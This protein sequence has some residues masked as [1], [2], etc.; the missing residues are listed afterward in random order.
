[1]SQVMSRKLLKGEAVLSELAAA[2]SEEFQI[3]IGEAQKK[4][5]EKLRNEVKVTTVASD[6][7]EYILTNNPGTDIAIYAQHPFYTLN[8]YRVDS[9]KTLQRCLTALSI[10]FSAPQEDL[11]VSSRVATQLKRVEL[12]EAIEGEGAAPGAEEGLADEAFLPGLPSASAEPANQ[13]QQEEQGQGQGQIPSEKDVMNVGDADVLPDYLDSFMMDY[14]ED[15]QEQTLEEQHNAE[16]IKQIVSAK[17]EEKVKSQT[18]PREELQDIPNLPSAQLQVQAEE[19]DEPAEPLTIANFFI[20]KLKEADRRL[21]DYTKNHPSLKKY[22]SQCQVTHMRQPA[23][24]TEAKYNEMLNE[25]ADDDVVFILYPLEKGEASIPPAGTE[26]YTV[27]RY[28]SSLQN[29]NYYLCSKYFCVRDEILIREKDLRGTRL[30]RPVRRNDG[31]V[32]RET[33]APMTCPFC[34]GTIITNRDTPGSNQTVL[35][36]TIK[37]TTK[38]GRHLYI[39]FLKK[40]QHPDGFPLPCCFMDEH[41]IRY[42]DPLY[43]KYRESLKESSGAPEKGSV[44]VATDAGKAVLEE[45]DD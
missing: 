34:E 13:E 18:L 8:F 3:D 32:L 27:L 22:V 39:S 19:K 41:P 21:F 30:R 4:V 33:K 45:D 20:N 35:E 17:I 44:T 11:Q 43:Q 5:A 9:Y 29:Q 15:L 28:G 10:L 7:H 36:R 37:P 26:F 25:Y 2:V 12:R 1:M 6:T 14:E 24:L 16:E 38:D 42:T 31:T 23:V 40:T